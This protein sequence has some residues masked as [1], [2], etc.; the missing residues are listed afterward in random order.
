MEKV[1]GANSLTDVEGISVGHF[2]D[3]E[4]LT[5]VTI[6]LTGDG[7]VGGGVDV[8]GG[9]PGNRET[10][11]LDPVNLVERVHAVAIC[12][13]SGY[14][15]NAVGGV[16]RFL[17]DRGVGFSVGDGRVVPIVPAAVLF[18]L[19][20]G[21][22]EGHI[23]EEFG[24]KASEN[25][26]KGPIPQGNVGAGTRAVSGELKGGIGMASDTLDSGITVGG[27]VA[28]NSFGSPVD[29]KRD[30]SMDVTW[31]KSE[32]FLTS[33]RPH[34][35]AKKC[36]LQSIQKEWDDTQ[37]SV[38]W[39]PMLTLP[40]PRQ[41]KLPRWLTTVPPGLSGQPTPCSTE[42]PYLF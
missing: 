3:L 19:G 31:K 18:D 27:L 4:L 17:E 12:G 5:G 38:W 6:V 32:N 21:Q 15:L 30:N 22:K 36:H 23:S 7:A 28:L 42:T 26:T 24:Y 11:L 8:R 1:T 14:G 2:T 29:P 34:H 25:A 40:R 41:Q 37:R 16:M 33:N 9:A 20:R 13:N 39:Q 35:S 10:D